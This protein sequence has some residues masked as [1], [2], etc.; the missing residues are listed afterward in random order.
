[1][2][3]P[4][5]IVGR[6]C[7]LPDALSPQDLWTNI[8]AGRLSLRS[9]PAE[10]W[11]IDQAP[12]TTDTAASG[13]PGRVWP[14][15]GGFVS[16]FDE[17]FDPTD[18]L[19]RTEDLAGL[20]PSFHWVMHCGQQA[21]REAGITGPHDRAGLVVGNVGYPTSGMALF[22]ERIWARALPPE[23]RERAEEEVAADPRDRFCW[24]FAAHLA[25][26]ALGLESG[27][28]AIEAACASS[29]YGIKLAVD[30]LH[31]RSADLMLAAAVT[32]ADALWVHM[33]F[34]A[35]RAMS[36][37]GRSRPFHRLADGLV[38][39]E[40]A[41]CVALMRLADALRA[42]TPVLAV[43]RGIGLSNDGRGKGLLAPCQAG[44]ERA[45]WQAYRSAQIAPESVTLAECHATGTLVGD[46]VEVRGMAR[47]FSGVPDLPIGSLKSNIGHPVT[48]AGLAGLLKLIGAMQA[49]V[50][51][52]TL[53]AEEP[54]ED[55]EGT[56][57]RPLTENEPWQGRRRAALS[58]YGFGG[59]NAHLIL[60][61][62]DT[63]TD[64]G[65]VSPF[66]S[67]TRP[68]DRDD[69]PIAIVAIGARVAD[70]TDTASLI[71]AL[72]TGAVPPS[73]R[74]HV[75]VRLE[76]V[77]FPPNDLEQAHAQ[78]LL[79]LEAAREALSGRHLP[80]HRT[81]VLIG[82]G[83]DPEVARYCARQRFSAYSS[84][85]GGH[86][87]T[88]AV[89]TLGDAISPPLETAGVV[90]TMPNIVANRINSQ[91][92]LTGPGFSLFAEEASGLAALDIGR[93]ALERG[94]MDAVVVGAVDLSCEPVHE[95][96]LRRLGRDPRTGDA[97]VVLLLRRRSDALRHGEQVV[98][99]LDD[100][101]DLS[102][103]AGLHVGTGPAPD[104]GPAFDPVDQFGSAHAAQGLVA[105]AAAALALRHRAVPRP[106]GPADPLQ[107]NRIAEVTAEPL[108]APPV[109][110]RL[111]AATP[112]PWLAEAAPALRVFGGRDRREVISAVRSG[113]ESSDGPCRLAV[114]A[115][116][117]REMEER[118]RRAVR[119]LAG[120][121]A[122][123]PGTAFRATPLAGETAFVYSNGSAAYPGMG[124]R[125]A[126]AFPDLMD[127]VVRHWGP[128][129]APLARPDTAVRRML[130]A[131]VLGDL[132]TRISRDLL[133]IEPHA[134]LGYS[135]GE[136]GALISLRI[137]QDTASLV[138]RLARSRTFSHEL[139]GERRAVRHALQSTGAADP[140]WASHLVMAPPERVQA[141][142]ADDPA[143]HLLLVNE[144][145]SCVIGGSVDACARALGRLGD[146]TTEVLLDGDLAAHTPLLEEVREELRSLHH[147][148]VRTRQQDLRVYSGATGRSYTPTPD[149]IAD[150]LTAQILGTAD[151]ARSV[152]TAWEDGVRVFIEHGPQASCSHWISAT[153]DDREHLTIALDDPGNDEITTLLHAVAE[154]AAAGRPLES[155]PL[156]SRLSAA[157]RPR[158]P[159]HPRA[160][161]LPAH[162]PRIGEPVP[163][164]ETVRAMA[165]PP[166]PMPPP[167]PTPIPAPAAGALQNVPRDVPTGPSFDRAE[168]EQHASGKISDLFGPRYA[169]LD[170]R[171]RVTRMPE[172]PML[173]VD[174]VTGIDAEPRSTSKGTIWTE[175]EIT[176]AA[177][178]L[179]EC[180]RIPAG[181]LVEAGQA[182]LLLLSWLGVDLDLRDDRVYRLL[183]CDLTF[184]GGLPEVGQTLKY[185][186]GIDGRGEHNGVQLFS[187]HNQCRVGERPV[188]TVRNGQAGYFT[189]EEL[190][191]TH[192]I[193]WTPER[194]TPS[195]GHP[196]PPPTITTKKREFDQAEVRAFA[197]GK[198]EQC[199]GPAWRA[200][201]AHIR[202]PRIGR[203]RML[204]LRNVPQFSPHGGP[205]QRGYLRAELPITPAS[206]FFHGHFNNDPC[207]PGT[208]MLE[209]CLQAMAF[210]LAAMGYTIDRDGW[211]FEPVPEQTYRLM[212][213]GQ[214][215]PNSRRL[216]Y[217][218]FVSELRA[219]PE[220]TIHADVLCTVDGLKA[221]HATRLGLRL[222][223]D[224]P[225]TYWSRLGPPRTLSADEGGLAAIAQPESLPLEALGGLVG[226]RDPAP[227]AGGGD[228]RYGYGA[229]L[230]AAWGRPTH[231]FGS[232]YA[233]FDGPR[234]VARLP[235][236]PYLLVSRVTE[237]ERSTDAVEESA[238][239]ARPHS[240]IVA[241]YDVPKDAWYWAESGT[242][243]MPLAVLAEIVLQP[244][245]WLASYE[246]L[247]L[248]A[249]RDLRFRNL[250]GT[251][252]LISD[253][254]RDAGVLDTRTRLRGVSR[255]Q[256]II[257]AYFDMT[258]RAGD[259]EVF[260]GSATFGYFP[261]EALAQ[262]IGL[263]TTR[264][265]HDRV[266]QTGDTSIDLREHP[267]RH[268][269][270]R[271]RLAGPMLLPLD[272]ITGL[273]P[274]GG[275]AGLGR[276]RAVRDV[277]PD[278]WYFKAHFF[279]D[280]VQPGSLG[281]QA[282]HQLLGFYMIDRELHAGLS[283][284]G[285]ALAHPGHPLTW[286]FR[287]QVTPDTRRVT[288]EMEITGIG[289]DAAGRYA[290]ADASLWA[291]DL[292]IYEVRGAG[293]HLV[294]EPCGSRR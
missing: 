245:G 287:G 113:H 50:R 43:I 54:I 102:R 145:G 230:A 186:I 255:E 236:P 107:G 35:L 176:T 136:G 104:G 85:S 256:D 19:T 193:L 45:M 84:K 154:L 155:G 161:I 157:W 147:W 182:D 36:R 125:L 263:P 99:F 97:A 178:Y 244:C 152:R 172:P 197:E 257:I 59:N 228:V 160:L 249:Q 68:R 243:T 131:G 129:D 120:Q 238:N 133:A 77:R 226:H 44:Q 169:V 64:A 214:V 213:R 219:D 108:G 177:W 232:A 185:Q 198:P 40:G 269:S 166:E 258:C 149:A 130:A 110:I 201:R 165:P 60:D 290:T 42:E 231:A 14:D 34:T 17:V 90:G 23:V 12:R 225:L 210:Y 137:W 195:S 11:R 100:V 73:R 61:A 215:T 81:M 38:P 65:T 140:R 87:A 86:V 127:D 48:A 124:R 29:L 242:A 202:S 283:R 259:R 275:S 135:S 95:A 6:G 220:P 109:R 116:S 52:A 272:R 270:P 223:P 274:D 199:F 191:A 280:P 132:H 235:G 247:P 9:A 294:P 246:G 207:M 62:W 241:E 103:P 264:A 168:L 96:A 25:A 206:W 196:L 1:M 5:A 286:T 227:V 32:R 58:T 273:W 278:D 24:G 211:R 112:Q 174:R 47:V 27:A 119:W 170:Q 158:P 171:R 72:L 123:P 291:D 266:M 63:G 53:G 117:G 51:P 76:G 126:L 71:D 284:P 162:P 203:G 55:L 262:Q 7:V 141:V 277:D 156:F 91:F 250:G 248:T 146:R 4:I 18:L 285:F 134:A 118:C 106:A 180:G 8:A 239:P 282:V 192:G 10:R 175:T 181:L 46:A 260:D 194:S 150:A 229:M 83:C 105:V 216:T 151:F 200:T 143:V 82:M 67:V 188:L 271:L 74:E 240:G 204:L 39:A 153:L 115:R 218:V 221:F 41:A 93:R 49:R 173:L 267:S 279:Q 70:G 233:P 183:G 167:L 289:E 292:R 122:R 57:L 190:T 28:V 94:E 37:S 265:E 78:Q 142:I 179:D 31:D 66:P 184:H 88:D 159:D 217:E 163:P 138:A 16:G 164:T 281:L 189:D 268:S 98:A 89:G 222:G 13:V 288:V 252:T 212:C 144:P 187:F 121:G 21:L 79:V 139:T 75:E 261:P 2:F 80:A 30:R 22:A 254:R 3:E 69:D 276:L 148:P 293:L 128:L 251:G 101:G 111:R 253:V 20:D 208:L 234:T 237:V 26:R 15:V 224:W 56:P 33:G 92:D 114:A 209:G 205:W